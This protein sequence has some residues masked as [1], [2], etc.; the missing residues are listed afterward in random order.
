MSTQLFQNANV[1]EMIIVAVSIISYIVSFV[2]IFNPDTMR[3]GMGVL[4]FVHAGF[5]LY[6]INSFVNNQRLE[7]KMGLLVPYIAILISVVLYFVSLVLVNTTLFGAETKFVN[8]YG[9]T[10]VLPEK[11]AELLKIFDILLVVLFVFPIVI[12]AIILKFNTE[13]NVGGEISFAGFIGSIYSAIGLLIATVFSIIVMIIYPIVALFSYIFGVNAPVN[14]LFKSNVFS[15]N[16]INGAITAGV[17]LLTLIMVGLS[18]W[19]IV[20]A[21]D[22]SKLK[23]K[24]LMK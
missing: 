20:I 6:I 9:T 1:Y 17:T 11:Y 21:N 7:L 16:S 10:L 5:I 23:N 24:N 2:F 19:Q 12:Y 15:G 14:K 13:L 4:N 3:I 22:F 18:S 8:S